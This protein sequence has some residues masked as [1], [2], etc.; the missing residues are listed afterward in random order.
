MAEGVAVGLAVTPRALQVCE[1]GL[2]DL[3]G[4]PTRV[5]RLGQGLHLRPAEMCGPGAAICTL[6]LNPSDSRAQL[7]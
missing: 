4:T 2:R 1:L 6:R 5:T 3:E 7:G